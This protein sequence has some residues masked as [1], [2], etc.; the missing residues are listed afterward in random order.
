MVRYMAGCDDGPN[1]WTFLSAVEAGDEATAARE[2]L[3]IQPKL[4]KNAAAWKRSMDNALLHAA[5]SGKPVLVEAAIAEGADNWTK[6]LAGALLGRH[7]DLVK[8]FADKMGGV[9]F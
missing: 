1:L 4:S 5:I 7:K 9:D 6:G 3:A 8:F 2:F